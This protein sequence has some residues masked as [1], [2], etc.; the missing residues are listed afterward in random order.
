MMKSGLRWMLAGLL[1]FVFAGT[2]LAQKVPVEDFFKDPE[3]SNV[4]LS[5]TGEYIAVSVPQED[6][7]ILVVLKVDDMSVMGSWEH[8]PNRHVDSVRWV[9]DERFFMYVSR[10]LGRYDF[11]VGTPDVYASNVDGRRRTVIPNG[12][13]YQIVDTLEDDPDWVLVQRSIDSAYLFRLNVNDGRVRTVATAPLRYGAFL[14]D[15]SGELRY[16]IGM[17][18][19]RETVTL[20]R[21]GDGWTEIHRS[22]MGGSTLI[23]MGFDPDNRL[24][25]T[26][27]SEDG[28]PA[29]IF[30]L[31][32]ETDELTLLSGNDNVEPYSH[33]YSSDGRELLAVRYLDGLPE[34]D[35]I[36]TEHPEVLT[37][38]G[39][40]NAFPDH[41]VA[42]AG[43][44]RDGRFVLA[45]VYSDVDPGT[46][47]LFDRQTN[48][49]KF[50]LAARSWIKP[51]QMSPMRAVSFTARDGT[52]VH[53]YITIP[54][55]SDG[56]NLPLIMHPHGGPHGPRDSWGFNP[57]VQFLAN[58][59][60][61]VL[62]VN[63]RGSGGYGNAFER[64]GYQNWGTTM[65]DDMTDGVEWAVR[66]GI[67]DPARVCTYGASYGGYAALQSVVRE[68]ERYRCTIG[69][70]G[71]YS[72]PLMLRD[73]DIPRS[74]S[75]RNYLAR[76]LPT[77]A[78]E[79]QA[80]SPA[81]NVDRINVP[82]MLVHGERDERVP[83]SQY[84]ALKR[85]LE[86]AGKPPEVE[87]LARNEGHGFQELEN[88]VRL[89][90]AMEEFLDKYIGPG[91]AN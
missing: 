36:N 61:A 18:E 20:R 3:F 81:F 39:L 90:N 55:N 34:T 13:T 84:R 70:V 35:F 2:A 53:G 68:P 74:E 51:E 78:G 33:L 1:A 47:Y 67:A 82:V 52:T 42:F 28:E 6:R 72:L 91:A 77:D 87:I 41:A 22:P 85:A 29:K 9:N 43:I 45:H 88:N 86:G 50:L 7:T 24:V 48:Q 37:Y 16:A 4:S 83:M 25:Y 27:V 30:A 59:G 58:R 44:S 54:R 32:A 73:G 89:Y 8:G 11:R 56:R 40:M 49:A 69:Y 38:A 21:T 12:G 57:E 46:Y 65:I 5:P 31:D 75:G 26:A 66:E 10:K 15:H 23:P 19:N 79:Q 71:V 17:E 64:K 76:V 14:V 63:F 62:Q 80:Q 60:Y